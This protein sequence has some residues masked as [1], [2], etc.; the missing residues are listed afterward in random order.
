MNPVSGRILDAMSAMTSASSRSGSWAIVYMIWAQF[1][2]SFAALIRL[3]TI[4]S[5]WLRDALQN[6]VIAMPKS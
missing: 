6:F 1:I 2:E 5:T 3:K 4:C